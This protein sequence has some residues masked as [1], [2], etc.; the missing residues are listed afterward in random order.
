MEQR[1]LTAAEG[2]GSGAARLRQALSLTALAIVYLL[3]GK[4]GLH[5]AL[6]HSSASAVWP[7]TGIALAAALYF[8]SRNVWPAVLVGAFFVNLS[9]SG[10]VLSSI[11]IAVGNTLEA[12]IGA[13][14]ITRHA[15]GARAFQ[16]S[17]DYLG[18]VLFGG[19]LGTATSA[20]IGSL[21]LVTS[22]EAARA[23]FTPIWLTWW[24]GDMAGA[25]I[26]APVLLLWLVPG[27]FEA[28]RSRPFEAV[29]LL[30]VMAVTGALVLAQAS[31]DPH[32]LTFLCIPPLIWT[33]FRFGQREAAT[34]VL[35]LS[36]MATWATVRGLGPFAT[37]DANQSLLLLQSFMVTIS[38]LTMFVAALVWERKAF[39]RERATLFEREK[40]AR[41]E[42]E[43]ANHAK[44]EFLAMLGHELRNP[45]AAISNALQVLSSP[46]APPGTA[47]RALNIVGRQTKHLTRLIDDLLDVS[48]I[49]SGKMLLAREPFDLAEVVKGCVALLQAAGRTSAHEIILQ[50]APAWVVGDT[51]RLAQV[52]DNLLTN[53]LKYAPVGRRIELRTEADHGEVRLSVTDDGV[54][55]GP[56]LL[57]HVFDLFTQGP[58][59]LE[60]AQGGLGLGLA[61]AQR[62]VLAHGGRMTA[63]SPVTTRGSRFTVVLPGIEAMKALAAVPVELAQDMSVVRRRILIVEDNDDVREGLRLQLN[64]AGHEVHE[65]T[66]GPEGIEAASRVRPDVILLDIGLPGMDGYGVAQELHQ[67][68]DAPKIVAI[69]GY[70]QP[71]DVERMRRA[72]ID[73]HLIKPVD[74]TELARCLK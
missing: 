65:A 7:P 14:L 9:V 39:E 16:R 58:R 29:L 5:F 12:V 62:I 2:D 36:T 44:D 50:L 71:E 64:L 28:V 40:E 20:T 61:L 72:G 45:L 53:A 10:S 74:A 13:T 22:G 41:A 23:A 31:A 15:A 24:L 73:C 30:V 21:V 27:R 3:A 59:T 54:G 33:A 63:S 57:P 42:A 8:G 38:L 51:A 34:A 47:D 26:V 69:T 25:L 37:T 4:L 49:S 11:G 43:R 46:V 70:G 52:V 67:R 35:L 56:E 19:L 32:P 68:G 66:T 17:K 55:I 1:I 48:R 18:F 6:V 60:R